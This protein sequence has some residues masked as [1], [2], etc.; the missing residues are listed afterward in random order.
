MYEIVYH[1]TIALYLNRIMLERAE[2][3]LHA[4]DE[5]IGHVR[6]TIRQSGH[7]A[8]VEYAMQESW[9]RCPQ[10]SKVSYF[11]LPFLVTQ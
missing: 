2:T 4:A 8:V 1:N 6:L 11:K 10:A 9:L 7:S 5:L 3:D